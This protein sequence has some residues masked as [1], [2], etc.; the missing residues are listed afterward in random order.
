M[1]RKGDIRAAFVNQWN[2]EH[3]DFQLTSKSLYDWQKKKQV[4]A[5]GKAHGQE[6]GYNRGKA[7]SPKITWNYLIPCTSSR[8]SHP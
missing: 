5:G 8:Q 1:T 2:K 3:G 7:Q 6:G 4:W